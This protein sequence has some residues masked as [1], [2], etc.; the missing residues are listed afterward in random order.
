[1]WPCVVSASK[2]G[3]VFPSCRPICPP[4]RR[5]RGL[6][7]SVNHTD[8]RPAWERYSH[9]GNALLTS[10]VMPAAKE[11]DMRR[12]SLV[13]GVVVAA[14]LV[15]AGTA[16][17]AAPWPGL[18]RN[19]SDGDLRYVAGR[20]SGKTVVRALRGDTVVESRTIDGSWGI[21]AVTMNGAGG[22]LSPDG[23]RLVLVELPNYQHLRRQS[24]F[25]VLSTASL[26]TE[27]TI[28]LKGE[29]GYDAQSP[30]GR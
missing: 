1:M 17:A 18:A 4:S 27:R 15:V 3:A 19:V 12:H 29:F 7:R 24:H 13:R 30:D 11:V 14:A 26:R 9:A 6:V 8:K 25:T 10:G 28:V 20:V 22:G 23:T 21:P 16:V 5:G 2:S